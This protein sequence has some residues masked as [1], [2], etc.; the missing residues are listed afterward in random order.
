MSQVEQL[1]HHFSTSHPT[2]TPELLSKQK[3]EIIPLLFDDI[4]KILSLYLN[5]Y[6][7]PK[8]DFSKS[9]GYSIIRS[10]GTEFSRL[11]IGFYIKSQDYNV[12]QFMDIGCTI[13]HNLEKFLKRVLDI[14]NPIFSRSYG[15][16]DIWTSHFKFKVNE[17]GWS[18]FYTFLS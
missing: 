3:E 1:N 15:K 16:H 12:Q 10:S 8:E 9:K 5:L 2:F 7:S 18:L 4:K 13:E 11:D 17:N 6:F 14:L